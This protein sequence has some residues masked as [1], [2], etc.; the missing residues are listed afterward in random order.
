MLVRSLQ[1]DAWSSWWEVDL[2]SIA[3]RARIS[4]GRVEKGLL[5]LQEKKILTFLVPEEGIRGYLVVPRV[6]AL[7]LDNKGLKR[8]QRRVRSRLKDVQRYAEKLMC[9]RRYLLSYFGE[10][11]D[12]HCGACDY[13]LGRHD[14]YRPSENDKALMLQI[15][16][17]I[18]AGEPEEKWVDAP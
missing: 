13:C 1:A 17:G 8:I 3:K 7:K 16:E 4:V 10:S 5:F 12:E 6:S 2:R 15:L 11:T 9:R 18:R 14:V